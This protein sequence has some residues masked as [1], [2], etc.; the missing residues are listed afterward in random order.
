MAIHQFFAGYV[1]SLNN[2][3]QR[4]KLRPPL[5][6]GNK[7]PKESASNV[8]TDWLCVTLRVTTGSRLIYSKSLSNRFQMI[9]VTVNTLKKSVNLVSGNP[10][11]KASRVIT[12][13][14][15]TTII[16]TTENF[17]G[18][19]Y[20][21]KHNPEFQ[22]IVLKKGKYTSSQASMHSHRI[23]LPGVF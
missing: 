19:I 11:L 5:P 21:C 16:Y 4:Q 23:Q 20:P 14:K 6:F 1:V 10:L 22:G 3:Y 9:T 15:T 7:Q 8:I 12:L 13:E 2:V 17:S 18:C